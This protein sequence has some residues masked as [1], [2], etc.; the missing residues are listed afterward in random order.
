MPSTATLLSNVDR[1]TTTRE[2]PGIQ[3]LEVD[4]E[5]VGS[6]VDLG[7]ERALGLSLAWENVGNGRVIEPTF[8]IVLECSDDDIAWRPFGADWRNGGEFGWVHL[9]RELSGSRAASV[10]SP[11]R[12]VRSRF[13]ILTNGAKE[14]GRT[15]FTLTARST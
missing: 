5:G 7:D 2:E 13:R 3:P 15:R 8:G 11:S 12:Y 1:F 6:S 9:A 10:V 14:K 4:S